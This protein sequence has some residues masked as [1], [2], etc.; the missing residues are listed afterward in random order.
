MI[1]S[2]E[3]WN[4]FLT[5]LFF[6]LQSKKIIVNWYIVTYLFYLTQETHVVTMSF[7]IWWTYKCSSCQTCRRNIY[8]L[9]C[10]YIFRLTFSYFAFQLTT[11]N[12]TSLP[13]IRRLRV[14]NYC[15]YTVQVIPTCYIKLLWSN[16]ILQ[17][18]EYTIALRKW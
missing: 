9:L 4:L 16:P 13:L 10:C 3:Y 1:S 17:I 2:L 15:V 12:T 14:N 18:Q 6:S 11:L 8:I 5:S 7:T